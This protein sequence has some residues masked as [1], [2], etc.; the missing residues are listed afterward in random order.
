MLMYIGNGHYCYSNSTAMFLSSI[1]EN[2]SPQLVEILTGVGLGAMIENEKTLYFSMRDPDDGIN[3]ALSILGFTAEE[4]QQ[5]SDLDDPFPLLKQQIKQ[6]P[7]IL[8]PLDMGELTY[9]PNHKNLNGS[10]HYVLGY[11]MD[12]ENIYVQDPAGFPFV[13]L[14]LDQFKKAWMAERIPYRK[15]I[16]KYWSTA[17]KVVTL[18]NNEIYE[19]AID[20][21]KRTYRE[22]EKVDIG[23]IGREAICFY[24]DQLL[25]ASI[26]ADT[27]GHT[28]F[29]LFQLSA[30]R[31]NDYAVYFKGRHSHLS[32]LKTEQAKVFGMCHSMSVN[33]DWKG[34]SEK[35]M[36]LAD[37]EDNFR[38][39][40]LKVGY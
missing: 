10:D 23:L 26:T 19:R 35:L 5:A 2:V 39:E 21:F 12:N 13:P 37:L 20:Y 25:N 17:K 4:H 34:I 31:A 36:K 40:I 15:G 30:R 28:T 6:N 27:I 22:F 38:L 16:N 24:A 3:Y 11:Q 18:D 14:S 9:H 29:F 33:K 8:G 1:G 7:V 32:V